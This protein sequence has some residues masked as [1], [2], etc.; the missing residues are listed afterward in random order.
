MR[1]ASPACEVQ[2]RERFS[3]T[4]RQRVF[5]RYSRSRFSSKMRIP[6]PPAQQDDYNFGTAAVRTP[7]AVQPPE[8]A[9]FPVACISV[10][11]M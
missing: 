10:L 11:I 8:P 9:C 3:M 4:A 1:T 7:V 2:D 5:K 6:I